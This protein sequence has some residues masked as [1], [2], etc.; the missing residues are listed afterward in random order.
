MVQ[1]LALFERAGSEYTLNGTTAG[2][3]SLVK[4]SWISGSRYVAVWTHDADG[5][6]PI[7]T[8]IR[9]QIFEAN[10]TPVG[11]E[12]TVNTGES[13]DQTNAVVAKLA[14]GG[15]VVAFEDRQPFSDGS[16]SS[17]R[18]QVYGADGAPIGQSRLANLTMNLDQSRPSVAGLEG[19]GFVI[20]WTDASQSGG[21]TAGAAVRG[22]LFTAA[23]DLSG[24]E[25]LVN[26]ITF[27]D[28][29]DSNV[30]ALAGGGFAVLWEDAS[31]QGVFN[32][33]VS[34]EDLGTDIAI[35]IFS[36]SASKVGPQ[37]VVDSM[38]PP[39]TYVFGDGNGTVT[40]QDPVAVLLEG[41]AIAVA[42]RDFDGYV[43][44]RLL[45]AD[46]TPSTAVFNVGDWSGTGHPAPA[47][48]ALADGGYAVSW[49]TNGDGLPDGSGSGILTRVFGAD[50]SPQGVEF[51][52]NSTTAG[53]QLGSTMLA[54]EDGGFLVAWQDGGSTDLS[55]QRFR[56]DPGSIGDIAL[57]VGSISRAAI[58]NVQA[59]I[60]SADGALNA[61]FTFQL[62]SD[63]TG[64]FRIEGDRLVV[65]DTALLYNYGADQATITFLATDPNGNS[66][67]ESIVI[68]LTAAPASALFEAGSEVAVTVPSPT[69][70]A[71]TPEI[72]ALPDGGW[73]LT[74]VEHTGSGLYDVKG[75]FYE[76]DGSAGAQL[77]LNTL[78]AGS[79]FAPLATLLENGN[80]VVTWAG[81]AQQSPT[82]GT[83]LDIR[84]QILDPSGAKIGAEFVVNTTTAQNQT[85]SVPV[86][87]A[88]G[89][90]LVTWAD[91]IVAGSN[92][93]IK[94]QFFASN[95]TKVGSEFTVNTTTTAGVQTD[96]YAAQLDNGTIVIA[97]GDSSLMGG[98]PSSSSVRARLYSAAGV[99]IGTEFLVNS[100]TLHSQSAPVVTALA[101][102]RF[103][104]VWGDTSEGTGSTGTFDPADIRAQIFDSAGNKVGGEILVNSETTGFQGQGSL[105]IAGVAADP[106]GGFVVSWATTFQSNADGDQA[107]V[108]AQL[109]GPDGG[110]IGSEFLVNQD[111]TGHQSTPAVAYLGDGDLVFAYW[112][113]TPRIGDNRGISMRRFDSAVQSTLPNPIEG[114]PGNDVLVGTSGADSI[115]GKV[116]LDRLSGLGGDDILR[117]DDGDDIL[118]GDGGNDEIY[119]GS[120][121]DLLDGGTGVDRTRGG[122]GNDVHH[123]DNVGD[124]VVEL[125]NEGADTVATSINYTLTANVE[126]LQALNIGGS[127]PLILTGNGLANF[128]WGTQGN[129][130][131]DGGGGADFM[132]GYA[133]NDF[134]HVDHVSDIAYELEGGG[135]DT[136]AT[137]ISY[138]LAANI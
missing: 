26:T 76:A 74:W 21:D 62:V 86:A 39:P 121:D 53:N 24:T 94:A 123:V 71:Q 13:G 84:A 16:G 4:V 75:Q 29:S 43:K 128:I 42:W 46:G 103:V 138:T 38:T 56:S 109:F 99:P 136:V 20:T 47:I 68:P 105:G 57:S 134:Y 95:G 90:F 70:S 83:M 110:K 107:S 135:A 98:D 28:Q 52:A 104:I 111:G 118:A 31:P 1:S 41:G 117:G 91:S 14:G 6:G 132:I 112:D 102:G 72:T 61:P 82:F 126:N 89:G 67:Q 44:T 58:E 122:L 87:L 116:G 125:L 11:A 97:W 36:S 30:V 127:D 73:F 100:T 120:G 55:A 63:P 66:F 130:A 27:R 9:A 22:Q 81:P 124:L 60:L 40:A 131:I 108:K 79:Q 106:D 93:D 33:S 7:Q 15:F 59:A 133:G 129:N 85:R 50:G 17:I 12:F 96:P 101:D 8:E 23:G 49:T 25:F 19:G 64:A 114:T 115:S 65:A 37:R 77:V 113:V 48:V 119:G 18:Y 137:V 32:G 51:Q 92:V 54:F 10:G 34:R 45:N 3:Q 2:V 5:A 78:T 35:Q 80:L 69:S 88:D